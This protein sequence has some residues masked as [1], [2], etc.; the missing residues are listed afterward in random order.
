MQ[1]KIFSI[2]AQEQYNFQII[3]AASARLTS[4]AMN[5]SAF[6]ADLYPDL[7]L[8]MTGL[9]GKFDWSLHWTPGDRGVSTAEADSA[10]DYPSLFRALQEEL[11]L[12][13]ELQ[14][15]EAEV[16]VIDDVKPP[17]EN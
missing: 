11:G 10:A 6:R 9:T 7:R 1:A 17:S 3:S 2:R 15:G 8:T 5:F 13:L 4:S 12:K 14:K 16:I